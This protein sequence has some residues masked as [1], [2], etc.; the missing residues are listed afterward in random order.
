M[1]FGRRQK[2]IMLRALNINLSRTIGDLKNSGIKVTVWDSAN[3]RING[4][5]FEERSNIL[6]CPQE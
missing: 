3:W 1:A 5:V 6:D 2:K 4:T